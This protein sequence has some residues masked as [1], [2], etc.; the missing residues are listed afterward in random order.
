REVPSG[1]EMLAHRRKVPRQHASE[2]IR[3][4]RSSGGW[5]VSLDCVVRLAVLPA[6]GKNADPARSHD[7]GKRRRRSQSVFEIALARGRV[8]VRRTSRAELCGNRAV[9]I[10][11]RRYPQKLLVAAEQKTGSGE[12]EERYRDL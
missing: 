5:L 11:P 4:H 1:D 2:L 9:G 7:P 12:E 8:R 10:E 3:R 6:R